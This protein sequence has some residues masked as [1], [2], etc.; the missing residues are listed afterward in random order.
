MKSLRKLCAGVLTVLLAALSLFG[1]VTADGSFET[2]EEA[3]SHISIGWCLGNTLDSYGSYITGNN[4]SD[5][6]TAWGNPVTTQ[7]MIQAV[8]DAGFNTIRIPVTWSQHIDD[9]GNVD[10]AWMA[11]VKEVVD[12]AYNLDMYVILNVHHDTGE[13]VSEPLRWI[14]ADTNI[15]NSTKTKY[16]GLWTNIANTFKD[17]DERLMFEGYNEM[18]DTNDTWNAPSTGATAYDAVNEYAQSFV[19]AV[20][21]T[22]G[23]NAERNLIVNT[24]VGSFDS[25]V[26][27]NFTV[28]TDSASDHL[29]CEVHC[30]SPWAFTGTA[31]SVTWTTVHDDFTDDDKT[32]IDGIMTALDNFSNRIGIPVIIGEFGA[33]DKNN[34]DQREAYGSYLIS[35]AAEYGIKC[36]IWDNGT[37]LGDSEGG[38][39]L[40]DR[41]QLSW[42]SPEYINALTSAA[43]STPRGESSSADEEPAETTASET[44][45]TETTQE[46]TVET[47]VADETEEA[48]ETDSISET[49]AASEETEKSSGKIPMGVWIGIGAAVLVAVYIGIYLLGRLQRYK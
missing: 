23:N 30:Y 16:E 27:S 3:V 2:A 19:N 31:E 45:A 8:K 49:E 20:R 15:Y 24:Y 42:T 34:N 32:E 13:N 36:I 44:S 43:V 47:T 9:N 38:Y 18:L 22:G 4:P 10:S 25:D 14:I 1:T 29:I 11:R 35:K 6:E 48:A 12:Y 37:N 46:T 26:L 17:Y 33:Q 5:Y 41:N 40:L 28:P 21:A 39:G 7:A